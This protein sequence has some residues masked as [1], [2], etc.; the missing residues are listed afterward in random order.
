MAAKAAIKAPRHAPWRQACAQ[1]RR[2]AVQRCSGAQSSAGA[3]PAHTRVATRVS[4]ARGGAQTG[5]AR[6]WRHVDA[7]R[8]RC[9]RHAARRRRSRQ[10]A[11]A[12]PGRERTSAARRAAPAQARAE[13]ACARPPRPPS[14]PRERRRAV[15]PARHFVRYS[16][17]ERRR[18]T[19]A[20]TPAQRRTAWRAWRGSL[21]RA[22]FAAHAR[23]SAPCRAAPRRS[24]APAPPRRAAGRA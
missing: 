1:R 24:R 8:I 6:A 2:R 21:R 19:A 16:S 13:R 23:C 4:A 7:V 15:W 17:V 9:V 14:R 11:K 3:S 10:E 5:A 12:K 20:C 18:S 22:I